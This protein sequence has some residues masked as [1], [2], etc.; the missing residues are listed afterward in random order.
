M[1]AE[2]L[3]FIKKLIVDYDISEEPETLKKLINLS[4]DSLK[5]IKEMNE[6]DVVLTIYFL[7][8]VNSEMYKPEELF[9]IIKTIKET[10]KDLS[11]TILVNTFLETNLL[12]HPFY[13][14]VVNKLNK[15]ESVNGFN[16]CVSLLCLECI[17]R[18]EFSIELLES[19]NGITKIQEEIIEKIFSVNVPYEHNGESYKALI[20]LAKKVKTD[21]QKEIFEEILNSVGFVK[22]P[23]MALNILALVVKTDNIHVLN[24]ILNKYN[25]YY[26]E[27]EEPK[28][29]YEEILDSLDPYRSVTN[30]GELVDITA[31]NGDTDYL[32]EKLSSFGDKEISCRT[33]VKV[34]S[35]FNKEKS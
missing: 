30:V 9:K 33:R 11:S 22:E 2:N 3:E 26:E 31:K 28:T 15:I 18:D 7:R 19:L 17:W 6:Y 5:I 12:K 34:N 8:N 25:N 29:V 20:S 13:D 4:S 1:K 32:L 21:A 27:R 23:R 10:K 14:K 16:A 24:T 35:P